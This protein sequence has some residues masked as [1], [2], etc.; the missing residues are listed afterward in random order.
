MKL[1]LDIGNS[2]IKWALIAADGEWIDKGAC[3]HHSSD[4]QQWLN[5]ITHQPGSVWCVCVAEQTMY[6]QL[7]QQLLQRWPQLKIT[8]IA[9]T[10]FFELHHSGSEARDTSAESQ[11][12]GLGII[13][14][15][16][17]PQSLGADRWAALIA[18]NA[19]QPNQRLL[20]ADC[21]TAVTLDIL[22][23]REHQGGYILPGLTTMQR[24][25]QQSTADLPLVAG[26]GVQLADNTADAIRHGC[27]ISIIAALE[28]AMQNHACE[29]CLL[30]GG[31]AAV[32]APQLKIPLLEVS[33]LVL[34][35]LELLSLIDN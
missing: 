3:T 8:R 18:A 5:T 2:R 23:K 14:A 35:G 4:I 16:S 33:D 20:I 10:A 26:I 31:D 27:T 6:T 21:G 7:Q 17:E 15:Y 28:W 11:Q 19:R 29:L 34:Q 12:T 32:L 30:T 25:L 9:S 24:S 1:L 13:T 22:D